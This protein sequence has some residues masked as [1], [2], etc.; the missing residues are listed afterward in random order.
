MPHFERVHSGGHYPF[1]VAAGAA[2]G[3][4]AA[5]QRAKPRL[6]LHCRR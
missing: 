6:L 4:A 5:L 2:I 3:L 1:D